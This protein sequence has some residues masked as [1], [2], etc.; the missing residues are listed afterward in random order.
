VVTRGTHIPDPNAALPR[1]TIKDAAVFAVR[2][3]IT[4]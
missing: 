3:V 4:C 2:S 1:A